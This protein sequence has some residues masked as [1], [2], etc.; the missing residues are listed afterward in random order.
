MA[1]IRTPENILI[2]LARLEDEL[3]ALV[4]EVWGAVDEPFGE[5]LGALR[6]STTAEEARR[7]AVALVRMLKPHAK[8]MRRLNAEIAAVAALREAVESDLA[9]VAARMGFSAA[10][11]SAS[12]TILLQMLPSVA[13]AE[14]GSRHIWIKPGGLE[15]ATSLKLKNIDPSPA[16]LVTLGAGL[17]TAG[18]DMLDKPHP[19]VIAAGLLASMASMAEM[20]TGQIE[21]REAS[22][23]WGLI[24]ARDG[25][26]A[27]GEAAIVRHTNITRQRLGLEALDAREVR[28]AL[29][30]LGEMKSVA[31]TV[32]PA[33]RW[34]IVE[35]FTIK[36]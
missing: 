26:G 17:V 19:L 32:G 28:N 23:F 13:E 27:A 30:R 2:A 21:E 12:A 22:V 36:R 25:T 4:G 9:D 1:H 18:S 5:T 16:D 3:P 24:K 10:G 15:G 11:V 33:D 35:R 29:Q 7:L 31:R 20:A 6:A 34:R 14:E 8:A